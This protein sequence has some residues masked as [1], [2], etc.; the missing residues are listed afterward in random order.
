MTLSERVR[1]HPFRW[2][3]GI[4][5]GIASLLW[6]YAIVHQVLWPDYAG[7][8]VPLADH[9][10]AERAAAAKAHPYWAA[11]SDGVPLSLMG[12]WR[13]PEVSMFLFFPGA[14]TVA[15]ILVAWL[16]WGGQGLAALLSLYKPILGNQTW[17]EG[18]RLYAALLLIIAGAAGLAAAVSWFMS[19]EAGHRALY[20]AY[21]LRSVGF[22]VSA[23]GVALFMNQGGL[24]EEMGWR[25]FAWPLLAERMA[26]PLV[27]AVLLGTV[28]ALW[29]F[30]REVPL[31][32]TGQTG[33]VDLLIGQGRFIVSCVASSIVMVYFVNLAG[34]SVWPAI[35]VHGTLNMIFGA[36]KLA[37]DGA[38]GG[39]N[40]YNASLWVWV[41]SAVIVLLIAGKDLA[42]STR[43]RLHGGDGRTDPARLWSRPLSTEEAQHAA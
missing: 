19:G 42:W 29:H 40:T 23:W 26:S 9:F 32:L 27:A 14:P 4:A 15:A 25:G 30:P 12:Y 28:W 36:F 3:Y 21:G 2:F 38:G 41:I 6:T 43:K 22:F 13:V 18:L 16:G 17:R 37:P 11:H 7:P 10:Y 39:G 35:M 33:P 8:G 1:R 34:G 20:E 24:L 31:I 5:F